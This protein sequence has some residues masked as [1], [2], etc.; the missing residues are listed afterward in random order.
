MADVAYTEEEDRA[1]MKAFNR[2]TDAITRRSLYWNMFPQGRDRPFKDVRARYAYLFREICQGS[3]TFTSD[4]DSDSVTDS[5]DEGEVEYRGGDPCLSALKR[6]AETLD[7]NELINLEKELNN[8]LESVAK[9][10]KFLA[11][12]ND[13]TLPECSIC[14]NM[15][16][17]NNIMVT[18][19]KHTM[20]TQCTVNLLTQPL[21]YYGQTHH[22]CPI[23]RTTL[24]GV[25]SI[26]SMPGNAT[27]GDIFKHF[28]K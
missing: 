24:D 17:G 14:M 7:E 9:R 27:N 22:K 16:D 11:N 12:C 21:S 26:I 13:M 8:T 4:S 28:N 20:C 2:S 3:R 10:R 18:K 6:K 15:C 25:N 19:C 5:E 1:I 23:C